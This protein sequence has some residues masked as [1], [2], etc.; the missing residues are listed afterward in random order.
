MRSFLAHAGALAALLCLLGAP[1]LAAAPATLHSDHPLN[2]TLWDTRSGQAVDEIAL[3][4]EAAKARW[5][6]LGEKHDNAE[7]HRLQARVVDA[8]G[9]AG[10]RMAV[11]WEMAEP[12][13][14]AALK[15]ARLETVGELGKALDWEGR[16][17][18]AWADYQPIAEAALRHGLP[19]LPGKPSRSL[20]RSV[21][22]GEALPDDLATRLDTA[23]PYPADVEAALLAELAESHCGALPRAA[24][25]PMARVQRLWDAWMADSLRAATA[26]P[27]N[28]DGA[29]LIAGGGHV[30]ADRAVPWHLPQGTAGDTVTVAM[31]EVVDGRNDVSNYP[32]FDPRRFD[33][34]W[35]TARVDD[36]DPCAAF[37]AQPAPAQPASD[38][39]APDRPA[40]D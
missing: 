37:P 14:A 8:L 7:H 15:D 12:E 16:G 25:A 27:L 22:R 18:P 30:R 29:V 38:R 5:V 13:Q 4:S 9:R 31:V 36:D 6:L 17:W 19:M 2:G 28:A 3:F 21:S 32:A 10:R 34:V 24:L 39:P 11:V 23:R 1:N 26:P 20:V 40:A 35:F 33:Y